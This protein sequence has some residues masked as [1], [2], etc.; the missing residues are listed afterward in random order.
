MHTQIEF[1]CSYQIECTMK[2]FM[3]KTWRIHFSPGLH[4]SH[5]KSPMYLVVCASVGSSHPQTCCHRWTCPQCRCGWWNL[6]PGTWT[7]GW[8]D[9]K[10][11][12][13]S[14]NL[15]R[16]CR[17][18]GSSQLSLARHQGATGENIG[19][20]EGNLTQGLSKMTNKANLRDLIAVM[21]VILPK[22]DPKR[23]FF[24]PPC[25]WNLMEPPPSP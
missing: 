14:R 21:V 20:C 25:P 11:S 17:E 13:W 16:Q 10:W 3:G 5:M 1:H 22:S 2:S 12:P 24:Q 19:T 15:S 8:H 9:G 23:W 18:H 4:C 6:H 7:G